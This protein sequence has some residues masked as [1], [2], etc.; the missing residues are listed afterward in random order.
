M[1]IIN[2]GLIGPG[3]IARRVARGIELAKNARLAA[4]GSRNIA[5]AKEFASEFGAKAYLNDDLLKDGNIDAI[6]LAIPNAYH[7]EY[8]KK[9]LLANKHVICEKPLVVTS[10]QCEELFALAFSR[11]LILMEA[12]K[13]DFLPLTY[14]VR[15][16]LASGN[17]GKL[18]YLDG[19][20]SSVTSGKPGSWVFDEK[21]GGGLRDVGIYPISYCNLLANSKIKKTMTITKD[22]DQGLDLLGQSV[23]L[24]ENGV[25]ATCTS[26]LE[27]NTVNAIHIYTDRGYF[28]IRD[29]WKTGKG[30]FVHNDGTIEEI[31]CEMA[32]DFKYEVEHFAS[33]IIEGLKESPI[34]SY[35]ATMEII[36]VFEGRR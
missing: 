29:F 34:A 3:N 26:G 11:N 10:S 14:K 35:E 31:E 9:A 6:Y 18:I 22:S 36:K 2:I 16:M 30:Q 23:M 5:R 1:Q 4:V 28:Y 24:Y 27:L 12:M 20:Y 8:I 7:Y 15:E 13:S 32:N 25:L 33:C 19:K 21:T 17:Y